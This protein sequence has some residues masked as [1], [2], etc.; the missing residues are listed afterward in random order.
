MGHSCIFVNAHPSAS[1]RVYI[2]LYDLCVTNVP[3]TV[4]TYLPGAI[5]QHTWSP[6]APKI[7]WQ[8]RI[9]LLLLFTENQI[10]LILRPS[11]EH[12]HY[13]FNNCTS[14]PP[15]NFPNSSEFSFSRNNLLHPSPA[16]QLNSITFLPPVPLPLF[17]FLPPFQPARTHPSRMLVVRPLNQRKVGR[18]TAGPA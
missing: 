13:L 1:A 9:P 8:R 11:A 2:Q 18:A 14:H 15:T 4:V 3:S 5:V 6:L 16:H 12:I 7:C 10:K 17:S